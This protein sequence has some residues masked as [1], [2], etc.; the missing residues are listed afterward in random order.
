MKSIRIQHT[1]FTVV[2]NGKQANEIRKYAEIMA[3]WIDYI[4]RKEGF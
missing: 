2:G 3:S 4:L 1:Y